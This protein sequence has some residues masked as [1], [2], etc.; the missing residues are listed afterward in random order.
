MFLCHEL[1]G[2]S[3]QDTIN[4][5]HK[6]LYVDNVHVRS[7]FFKLNHAQTPQYNAH[8]VLL[9]YLKQVMGLKII[10]S[11]EFTKANF[12]IGL[13]SSAYSTYSHE[14]LIFVSSAT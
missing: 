11:T 7:I 9:K 3:L 10:V 2:E 6:F 1:R 8:V 12:V 14:N 5:V 13:L 4:S